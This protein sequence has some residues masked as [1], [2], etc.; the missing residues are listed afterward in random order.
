[1]PRASRLSSATSLARSLSIAR[2]LSLSTLRPLP[3]FRPCPLSPL[4]CDRNF[5]SPSLTLYSLFTLS[6]SLSHSLSSLSISWLGLEGS[7][8][9]TQPQL[10]TFV[11]LTQVCC[12]GITPRSSAILALVGSQACVPRI[13]RLSRDVRDCARML[14]RAASTFLLPHSFLLSCP[15]VDRRNSV[16]LQF[17]IFTF[18]SSHYFRV[19]RTPRPDAR[20]ISPIR[21]APQNRHT[22]IRARPPALRGGHSNAAVQQK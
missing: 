5:L 22:M 13:P 14:S 7:L 16:I 2:I 10:R 8:A 19:L 15:I 12:V 18:V 6:L 21:W 9:C 4:P 1:M 11:Q 3:L 20:D 17:V